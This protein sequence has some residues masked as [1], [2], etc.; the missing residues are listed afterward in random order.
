VKDSLIPLIMGLIFLA[1]GSVC[2]FWPQKVQEYALR[3]S[4]QG[5]GRYSLFLGWIK[6]PSYVWTLRVIGIIA[7]SLFVLS[8]FITIKQTGKHG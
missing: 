4:G 1:V 3:W 7:I 2:L 8:L 5:L 6:T